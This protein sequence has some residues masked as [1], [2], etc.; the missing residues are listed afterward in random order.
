MLMILLLILPQNNN[1]NNNKNFRPL[2]K[3]RV[4]TVVCHELAYQWFDNLVTM[5]W[6]DDLW[7]NEGFASWAENW[8][9]SVLFPHYRRW[10]QFV[11]NHLGCALS[12]DG[13]R[14]G[15]PIQV[16]IGD[17]E[18]VEE[19]FDAILHCKG[20][21]VVPM[22]RAVLGFRVFREGLRNYM[23]KHAYDNTKTINLWTAW[24]VVSQLPVGEMIK[25]WT[26]Q[27]GFPLV[28]ITKEEI[29]SENKTIKL[30]LEQSCFLG[31]GS[32]ATTKE[33][34][35]KLWTILILNQTLDGTLKDMTLMRDKTAIVKI[36]F[37]GNNNKFWI[38]LNRGQEVPMCVQYFTTLFERLSVAICL[39]NTTTS[40]YD[41]KNYDVSPVDH[42]GL[43][44]DTYAL[45]KG[46]LNAAR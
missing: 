21:S 29:D 30:K 17:A 13:L 23:K 37:D 19:V 16:P 40:D 20:G 4:C 25:L 38:K 43:L 35:D 2:Q 32:S 7:L 3:Q 8:S 34:E 39:Q 5:A 6:W 42:V 26:E 28:T 24:E 14:S 33:E 18:E 1:K 10:D 41:N 27:M 46:E 22:L 11:T 15:H 31:D 36:P 45:V 44:Q 9:S 12:L